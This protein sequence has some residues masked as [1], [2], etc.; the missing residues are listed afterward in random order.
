MTEENLNNMAGINHENKSGDK[1]TTAL[2]VNGEDV[3]SQIMKEVQEEFVTSDRKVYKAGLRSLMIQ[4]Q[5]LNKQKVEIDKEINELRA[6]RDALGE[7]FTKGELQSVEDARGVTMYV[8]NIR[9]H[10]DD[11]DIDNQFI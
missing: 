5:Q 4:E 1:V 9:E 6:A 3:R 11:N 7:A 10:F 2:A 8:K